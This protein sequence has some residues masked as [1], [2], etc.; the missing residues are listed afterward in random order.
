MDNEREA[1]WTTGNERDENYG[2][3]DS[4]TRLSIFFF[5][6]LHDARKTDDGAV[7]IGIFIWDGILVL[8]RLFYIDQLGYEPSIVL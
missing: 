4:C 2:H 5:V 6:L 8:V 3:G 7:C 1:L